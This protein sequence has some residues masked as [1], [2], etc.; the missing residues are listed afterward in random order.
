MWAKSVQDARELLDCPQE[1]FQKNVMLWGGICLKGLIPDNGPLF[2][3]EVKEEAID[4]GVQLGQK[5]GINGAC[6][7]WMITNKVVPL[8]RQLYGGREVWQ[9]DNARIHR[10][11]AA[12]QACQAFAQRVPVHLQAPK[13][14]D[15]WP[16]ENLWGILSDRVKRRQPK[17][18]DER[19][20]YI[21]EEW[22]KIDQ[23]KQLIKRLMQSIPKRLEAVIRVGGQQI[24]RSDYADLPEANNNQ[25]NVPNNN[26]DAVDA[27]PPQ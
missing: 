16:V 6:Y 9:D 14:A 2:A 15:V 10:C 3:H 1:K 7:A 24:R 23:D 19:S 5:G 11:G 4:A 12:L 21:V 8:V 26:N 25:A 17:T 18:S 20:L 27:A 13:M 22:V